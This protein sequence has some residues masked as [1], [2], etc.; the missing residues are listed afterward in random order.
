MGEDASSAGAKR[1]K[2]GVRLVRGPFVQ[3]GANAEE[4]RDED[5]FLTYAAKLREQGR[6]L[7]RG[8]RGAAHGG[9]DR[10]PSR[11]EWQAKKPP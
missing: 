6:R 1:G 2:Y 5:S 9:G 10:A 8:L 4:C 11:V 7:S 3:L